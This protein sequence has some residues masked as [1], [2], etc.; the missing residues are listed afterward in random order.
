MV[1]GGEGIYIV[2]LYNNGWLLN[3]VLFYMVCNTVWCF[4]LAALYF[5]DFPIRM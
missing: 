1:S 2:I 3:S 4:I 5:G